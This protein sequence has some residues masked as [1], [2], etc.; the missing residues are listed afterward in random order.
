MSVD[1]HTSKQ[2]TVP[3]RSLAQLNAE[4]I[5]ASHKADET[6]DETEFER[7]SDERWR[8]EDEILA[9]GALA[10]KVKV[11]ARRAGGGHDVADDLIE[12]AAGL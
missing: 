2:K 12:I 4:L 3:F 6:G 7:L 10:D 1:T 8:A 11:L 9:S 5:E